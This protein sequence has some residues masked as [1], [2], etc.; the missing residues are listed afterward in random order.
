M[1]NPTARQMFLSART[2]RKEERLA[3]E[4]NFYANLYLSNGLWKTTNTHRLDDVNRLI[5]ECIR[6][7]RLDGVLQVL[8]VAVSSGITTIE[9]A[10][11]LRSEGLLF[12]IIGTDIAINGSLISYGRLFHVLCDAR[13]KALQFEMLGHPI[14]NRLGAG[15]RCWRGSVQ[16]LVGRM[17]FYFLSRPCFNSM[18]RPASTPICFLT[19]RWREEPNVTFVEEDLLSSPLDKRQYHVIRACN[20]LNPQVFSQDQLVTAISQLCARLISGGFLF[21]VRT[22]AHGSNHGAAYELQKDGALRH[23]ASLGN[24]CEVESAV[25]SANAGRFRVHI[26]TAE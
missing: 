18:I 10:Q 25:L 26:S 4:N 17:V 15:L 9:L 23:Y 16:V 24:G 6:G 20:I 22:I 1:N 5:L 13:R 21:I 2:H 12:N 8:D 19:E 14:A 11:S 7:R 3:W